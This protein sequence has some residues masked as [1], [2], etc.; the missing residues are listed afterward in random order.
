MPRFPR[1]LQARSIWRRSR[2]GGARATIRRYRR[3]AHAIG[4]DQ[5]IELT[6]ASQYSFGVDHQVE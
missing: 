5:E 6:V 2:S 3:D 4:G 1:G